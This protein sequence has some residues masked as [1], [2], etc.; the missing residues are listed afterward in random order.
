MAK[1]HIPV[2]VVER[3]PDNIYAHASW[4]GPGLYLGP[5]GSLYLVVDSI[6]MMMPVGS[7]ALLVSESGSQTAQVPPPAHSDHNFLLK[8]V[9]ISQNPALAKDLTA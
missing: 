9:A 5:N 7:Q 3:L 6:V 4:P 1:S 2:K 8:L